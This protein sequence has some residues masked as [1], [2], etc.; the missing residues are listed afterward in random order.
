MANKFKFKKHKIPIP[1]QIANMSSL[2]PH[3]SYNMK[4]NSVTWI[5]TL[6][7]T[8][9]SEK[10]TVKIQYA[11]NSYPNV[12][13]VSPELKQR[14]TENIPHTYGGSRLCLY[15]PGTGECYGN[16]LIA[17]TIVPWT[18]LWLYYY[19]LWHAIGEWLGGGVHP[20]TNKKQEGVDE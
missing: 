1:V 3:F 17:K 12:W 9:M 18:S 14:D 11:I 19:E 8:A 4:N 20:P 2:F 13:V 6:Q 16:M 7:P 5:G 15:L 10:Y